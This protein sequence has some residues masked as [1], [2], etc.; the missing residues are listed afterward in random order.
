MI[1][2]DRRLFAGLP[3]LTDEGVLSMKKINYF[4]ENFESSFRQYTLALSLLDYLPRES[5]YK[6][7][8]KLT[9]FWLYH[10]I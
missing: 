10:Q 8:V 5:R 4:Q 9:S 6:Q 3:I 2:S 7:H 1:S